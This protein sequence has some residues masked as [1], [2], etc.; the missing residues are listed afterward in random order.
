LQ[1]S[2]GIEPTIVAGSGGIFE[3]KV[4][5]AIVCRRTVGHFPD[6]AEIVSAVTS[7]LAGQ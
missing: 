7:A 2:L 3:V 6:V 1:A 4:D 5:D